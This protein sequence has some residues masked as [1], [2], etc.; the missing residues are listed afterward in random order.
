LKLDVVLT[1]K[2]DI[3]PC[4]ADVQCRREVIPHVAQNEDGTV[5]REK[6][7]MKNSEKIQTS[8]LVNENMLKNIEILSGIT[9]GEVI[10]V[11]D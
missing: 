6:E 3:E 8:N 2:G 4:K 7:M 5:E 1:S 10:S 9:M 11:R